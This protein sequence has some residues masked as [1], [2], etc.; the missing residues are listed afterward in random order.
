MS[1][2]T[3]CHAQIDTGSAGTDTEVTRY[4]APPLPGKW[5]LEAAV[6]VPQVTLAADATDHATVT[7]SNGADDLG[8]ITSAT[9]ALT[10]G[11]PRVIAL[12]GGSALDFDGQ[13][14]AATIVLGKEGAG[15][16][17]HVVVELVW[18]KARE[19]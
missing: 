2:P 18:R 14:D 17:A 12:S 9:V 3:L 7:V 15:G 5:R 6:V 10:A 13:E 19:Q 8:D 11:T 16:T 1:T 4:L